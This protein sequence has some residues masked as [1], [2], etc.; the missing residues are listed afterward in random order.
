MSS[1]D[2]HIPVHAF[3]KLFTTY[4]DEGCISISFDNQLLKILFECE[5]GGNE[6]SKSSNTW[7][8]QATNYIFSLGYQKNLL[9]HKS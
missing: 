5:T 9:L 3:S 2:P 8:P 6:T 4:Q 7:K 1:H